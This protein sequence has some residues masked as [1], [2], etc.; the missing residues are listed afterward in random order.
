MTAT[1]FSRY[2]FSRTSETKSSN[3]HFM[4][5]KAL[6]YKKY[7]PRIPFIALHDSEQIEVGGVTVNVLAIVSS[8]FVE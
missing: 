5:F 3:L 8:N 7:L 2:I 6:T 1:Y 4:V